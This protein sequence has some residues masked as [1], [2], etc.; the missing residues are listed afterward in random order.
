MGLDPIPVIFLDQ[1]K[2]KQQMWTQIHEKLF[3]K[4]HEN[5]NDVAR[6]S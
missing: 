4:R 6:E 2:T 5:Y 3:L 1:N